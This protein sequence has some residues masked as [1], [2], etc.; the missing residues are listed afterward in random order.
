[1]SPGLHPPHLSPSAPTAQQTQVQTSTPEQPPGTQASV[2]G[3]AVC[4]E[5]PMG[6]RRAW[7]QE[8]VPRAPALR[9]GGFWV[10][11]PPSASRTTHF[12]RLSLVSASELREWLLSR[13]KQ[14][15]LQS[16]PHPFGSVP[17]ILLAMFPHR[18]GNA[19]AVP[20]ACTATRRGGLL[21][22]SAACS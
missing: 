21:H 4:P 14:G 9:A 22:S 13:A 3:K 18:V 6:D 10:S 2:P 11:E 16:S 15:S 12:F 5:Q 20:C 17:P 19:L 8:V 7:P 1:M